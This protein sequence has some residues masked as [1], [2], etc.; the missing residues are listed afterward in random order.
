[1]A[2]LRGTSLANVLRGLG[3]ELCTSKLSTEEE[4]SSANKGDEKFPLAKGLEVF[5]MKHHEC[6]LL[7]D[8]SCFFSSREVKLK[9]LE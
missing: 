1:M 6:R 8:R 2:L 9:S 7:S 3:K 4:R 5:A